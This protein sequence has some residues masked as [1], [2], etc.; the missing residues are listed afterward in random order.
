MT[1]RTFEREAFLARRSPAFSS[2]STLN[3][4]PNLRPPPHT[5][6]I[7]HVWN[8]SVSTG[9]QHTNK[10]RRRRRRRRVVRPALPF[11]LECA[12]FCTTTRSAE[13]HANDGDQKQ[14]EEPSAPRF[15]EGKEHS[16]N[17]IDAK[18]ERSIANNVRVL[19]SFYLRTQICRS[20]H[21]CT[22][23]RC[24]N[25]SP[26]MTR[27]GWK[28]ISSGQVSLTQASYLRFN[29]SRL[30]RRPRKTRRRP[31]SPRTSLC[32]QRRPRHTATSLPAAQRLTSKS[33]LKS[34]RNWLGRGK[35]EGKYRKARSRT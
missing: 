17:L 20:P 23:R 12:D 14:H 32:Q 11:R 7:K 30:Q 26:S 8:C 33:C 15:E 6:L 1:S 3:T 24:R 13:A 35:T 10:R 19:P 31:T 28:T 34:R 22:L 18:D 5:S 25:F 2:S 27:D 21:A 9:Y 16:H 4:P 29:S